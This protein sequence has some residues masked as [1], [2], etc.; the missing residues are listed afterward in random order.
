MEI[1]GSPRPFHDWYLDPAVCSWRTAYDLGCLVEI[2]DM[3][4]GRVWVCIIFFVDLL[5]FTTAAWLRL[6]I[7][8]F[9]RLAP[10]RVRSSVLR[11]VLLCSN[12]PHDHRLS[13]IE[14][15]LMNLT[16]VH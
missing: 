10:A 6:R 4:K 11:L 2:I 3:A 9:I 12:L 5:R 15:A 16:I 1:S 7:D 13:R 8:G 14:Q